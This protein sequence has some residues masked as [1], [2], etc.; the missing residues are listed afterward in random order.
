MVV[1]DR[2]PN[3]IVIFTDDHGYADLSCQGILNDVHTPHI[4]SLAKGGVRM[5][6]G[7]V[8]ASQCVP[9]RGG[10]LTGKYQQRFG[11]ENN[12]RDLAGF[13]AERTIAERLQAV[14]YAT[15]MI[16]K[17][18]LGPP[19]QITEHGFD[20]V[21][22]KNSNN[23]GWANYDLSGRDVEAGPEKSGLYHLDACS[24]AAQAFIKRHHGEPFFL[25]LAY[26][27]PHVPLDATDEYL[28]RFPGPMPERR[29]KALAMISAVDDGVGGIL[30]SLR[31]Y[32]VEDN[33][34]IFFIGDNGAPLKIHK[35]DAPGIGAGWDGSL[36]D[37]LNG[38]KG[39]VIE[40]GNR[41]PFL[42]YWKGKFPGA[43]VYEHPVISLDVAATAVAVAGLEDDPQLDGVNLVP[44]LA[45]Q[46]EGEPHEALFWRWTGQAA[47]RQGKWKYIQGGSRRYLFDLDTD[48][49]ETRNV[50]AAHPAIAERLARRLQ[51]WA[52]GLNPP[53]LDQPMAVAGSRYFDYYLDGKQASHP[54]FPAQAK[55][56]PTRRPTSAALM[57]KRDRNRD[58]RLTLAEY[59]G[60]P[61]G[62]NVPALTRQCKARDKNGD[63]F[64]TLQ[65]LEEGR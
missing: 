32:A 46:T 49:G 53:G 63:G 4:D 6:S 5:T 48:I 26:R 51:A 11:L 30:A 33:T 2:K 54:A 60:D 14:G 24:K 61:D 47:V 23:A 25:Y 15:G 41:V 64:L 29:R 8:T 9:S 28:E 39:T 19:G 16:G 20:D 43:Q 7:Y 57:K 36:N 50:I 65:E 34:L 40:G 3:I 59:I 38:E 18:H 1:A 52:Q 31:E 58:G 44:Y 10:L 22:F 42:V 45:G 55:S 13:N 21:Y 17:W 37:P 56:Q 12:G 62:R 27:A 35:L